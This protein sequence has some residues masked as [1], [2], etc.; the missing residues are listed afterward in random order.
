M[1]WGWRCWWWGGW[2]WVLCWLGVWASL[3]VV[4][5]LRVCAVRPLRFLTGC[6]AG[7]WVGGGRMSVRV[8]L[9][10]VCNGWLLVDGARW[11]GVW[12]R[13]L[14]VVVGWGGRGW[15]LCWLGVRASLW[16]VWVLRVCAVRPLRFLTGCSAGVTVGGGRMSVR[17]GLWSVCNGW[18]LVDGA[19]W[20]GVWVGGLLV[21]VGSGGRGWVL[22]WL[23]VRASLWVVWVLRV[24]ALRP[25]RFLTGCGAGVWV[26]GGSMSVRWG[27][28]PYVMSGC[29]LMVLAGMGCGLVGCW[30]WWGAP[31][32]P[33]C[34]WCA[35]AAPLG[36]MGVYRGSYVVGPCSGG[37]G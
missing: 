21:V 22:C 28:G 26:G 11:Y 1:V 2:G 12:V 33:W 9:W 30:W 29:W 34:C 31:T 16:V 6:G 32:R 14:L 7:V 36:S 4:L 5:V 20:Y 23:V 35:C 19:R 37:G 15:V 13:G 24:C 3:W 10:S 18:L 17:V 27:C 25:L 8:G